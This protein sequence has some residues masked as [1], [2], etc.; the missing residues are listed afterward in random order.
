MTNLISASPWR[1]GN[2]C[3]MMMMAYG[4]LKLQMLMSM[5]CFSDGPCIGNFKQR[6]N[7]DMQMN[8]SGVLSPVYLTD[9]FL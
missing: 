1:S 4:D 2:P 3:K 9:N 8:R 6:C 7:E 5:F